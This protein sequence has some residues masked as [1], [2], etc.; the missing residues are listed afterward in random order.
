[1]A[2][3]LR[4]QARALA[5]RLDP[6]RV[7]RFRMPR[8]GWW[9]PLPLAAAALFV[10]LPSW[11]RGAPEANVALEAAVDAQR[12]ELE[13]AIAELETDPERFRERIEL[14]EALL[15]DLDKEH[16]EK[17]EALSKLSEAMEELGKQLE[18]EQRQELEQRQLLEELAKGSETEKLA[19]EIA[20][21]DTEAA[22]HEL[23][24]LE[25][26]LRKEL[27]E[28][29]KSGADPERQKKIEEELERLRKVRAQLANL[30]NLKLSAMKTA[31]VLDLLGDF[32]GELGEIGDLDEDLSKVVDLPKEHRGCPT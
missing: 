2:E 28:L 21:G 25:E 7:F 5:E 15:R 9:L 30:K 27:E 22:E 11:L 18:E 3:H 20:E 29:K 31:Q 13:R 16:L 4:A 23:E 24:K 32:E 10:L 14:L 17:K 19:E 6:K 1:M 26:K 8:E 12:V